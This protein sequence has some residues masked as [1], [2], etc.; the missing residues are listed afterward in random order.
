MTMKRGFGKGCIYATNVANVLSTRI[1]SAM[2]FEVVLVLS[3]LRNIVTRRT[4]PGDQTSRDGGC[5]HFT[6]RRIV[7]EGK[8]LKM[9]CVSIETVQKSTSDEKSNREYCQI[10]GQDKGIIANVSILLAITGSSIHKAINYFC[11]KYKHNLFT[12]SSISSV[13]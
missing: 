5:Q 4:H 9:Q 2:F 13:H 12:L 8:A 7:C 3:I 6:L 10:N 1:P 11:N